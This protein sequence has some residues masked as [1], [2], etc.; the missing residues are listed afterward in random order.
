M[1]EYS[2]ASIESNIGN[3]NTHCVIKSFFNDIMAIQVFEDCTFDIG[4]KLTIKIFDKLK[5]YCTY[6]GNIKSI[7]NN[8]ITLHCVVLDNTIQRRKSKRLLMSTPTNINKIVINKKKL[9]NLDKAISMKVKDI[10][11][12]GILLE[13]H[14]DVPKEIN[15]II[16][17]PAGQEKI[18]IKTTTMRKYTKNDLYYYGCTFLVEDTEKES[19]LLKFINTNYINQIKNQTSSL[20]CYFNN[21]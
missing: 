9:L 4:D 8:I 12:T 20:S 2:S 11:S 19:L 16:D 1:Y 3:K 5:G 6:T 21:R 15:F 14:L 13:S 10:S 18:T 17:F 7:S